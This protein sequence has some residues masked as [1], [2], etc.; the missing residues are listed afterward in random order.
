MDEY[1]TFKVNCRRLQRIA[2]I[3]SRRK[4]HAADLIE[5]VL[6]HADAKAELGGL[7]PPL[8]LQTA[9]TR[10]PRWKANAWDIKLIKLVS[11]ACVW[12]VLHLAYCGIL[13]AG[14][15]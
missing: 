11:V 3:A 5:E 15:N 10:L 2:R 6:I 4:F 12:G 8:H 7:G 14:S 9:D 1:G 13:G